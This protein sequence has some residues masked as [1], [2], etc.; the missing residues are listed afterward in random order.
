MSRQLNRRA[1]LKRSALAAA[2]TVGFPYIVRPTALG[3]NGTV[4]PSNRLELAQLGCGSMGR[5]NMGA[6]LNLG[7]EVQVVAVCDVD[8]RHLDQAKRQV[9]GHYNTQDCRAYQDYRQMLDNEH[10]DIVSHAT[11]DHWHALTSV[12]CARKGIDM[13][14]EKPLSRTI[15]EG[16]L[17]CDAVKRYGIIWQTGSWQRSVGHFRRGAELAFNG[18][19]GKINYVEVGLP[20]GGQRSARQLLAVPDYLDWDLWLGPAPWRPYQDFGRGDPHWDWRWIMDYSGGQLTDWAGH[21]VDI[22]HWGLGLDDTGPVEIY[23]T[24]EYPADGVWDAPYG[25]EFFCTYAHG[26]Q[27]RVANQ[28]KL[29][30]GMG[31]CWY[32]EKGWIHV[33]R[34]GVR[35]SDPKILGSHIGPD[36]TRLYRSDHHQ[37][38]FIECVKT[39]RQTIT[40]AET[41]HRSLSVGL[42]GE[43]AMLTGRRLRWNPDTE[44]FVNDPDADR[45][46]MRA[47]RSPWIL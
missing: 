10:L 14:G 28:S 46:L 16:R 38:N 17:I 4:S 29:P 47:Y 39:R 32:G 13:Y 1:F 45:Y 44:R 35:A 42:L 8:K 20:N 12:D 40:P 34:G 24:G 41:A 3:M 23:G 37:R 43:I 2:G 21:H 30:H 22:A 11:P 19:I 27:M 5:S 26:L 6:F 36:E 9:D 15:G 7:A 18:H 31:V 25:Y 33:N